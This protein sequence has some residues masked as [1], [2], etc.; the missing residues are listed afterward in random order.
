MNDDEELIRGVLDPENQIRDEN[1]ESVT[2][3]ILEDLNKFLGIVLLIVFLMFCIFA[4]R[5]LYYTFKPQTQSEQQK[6]SS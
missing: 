6:T 2:T 3:R 1:N 4:V 5:K